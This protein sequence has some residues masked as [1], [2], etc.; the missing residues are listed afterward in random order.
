M[1]TFHELG[2][3]PKVGDLIIRTIQTDK[4]DNVYLITNIVGDTYTVH[5]QGY[6]LHER[7]LKSYYSP[8]KQDTK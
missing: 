7:H 3:L 5:K 8:L 1:K 6:P 4:S 2:T